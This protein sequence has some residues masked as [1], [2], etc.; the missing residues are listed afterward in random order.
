[1]PN[2][3]FQKISAFLTGGLV[4]FGAIPAFA[5]FTTIPNSNDVVFSSA[6]LTVSSG[7]GTSGDPWVVNLPT[8]PS[9]I[10]L[11]LSTV[12]T[13]DYT[14]NV[15][16]P[17][18]SLV[19]ANIIGPKC[20]VTIPS[21]PFGQTTVVEIDVRNGVMA[22][23]SLVPPVLGGSSPTETEAPTPAK[24]SGPE[25]SG[26]AG[27]GIMT[28][29][30]GK[31]EGKRLNEI[32]SIEIGGKA[33]TF[34]ANSTTELEL[35]LPAGLAPGLY[36]LVINSSAGK[37][38]HIN[39]I[40]VREP[41]KSFSI[42]TRSTGKISNDQYI[43]HSLIASMQIPELN[44]ARCVVNASSMAMAKAMANRLCAVVKASNPNIE[45]TI[46]EPRSTV[47][48]DAVYARVSYGWN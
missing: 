24:Y 18:S 36:D 42:T 37:L 47:K 43:E 35:S 4:M 23:V 34:N 11:Y 33:A 32:S 3:H 19:F 48:G 21:F 25:F 13:S 45:T 9:Y 16:S 12:T 27:M 8:S 39:A 40:Q 26:L 7:D 30:T 10:D 29:S 41:R 17:T 14:C 6:G 38:T 2:T 1:M 28:G 44:K 5:T 20:E 22:Y 31:L 46:V 15:V